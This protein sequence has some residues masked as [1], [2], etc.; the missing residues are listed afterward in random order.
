MQT[1]SIVPITHSKILP[2]KQDL[3]LLVVLAL[4]DGTMGTTEL[5]SQGCKAGPNN[6][7]ELPFRTK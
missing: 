5:K 4:P 7:M 3:N 1:V 2:W 6:S